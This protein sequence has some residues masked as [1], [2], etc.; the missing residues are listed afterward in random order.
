MSAER[1]N[2]EAANWLALLDRGT[3]AEMRAAFDRWKAADA[4]HVVA[5]ARLAN[6]W[7]RLD[8]LSALHTPDT[9]APAGEALGS[10]PARQRTLRHA[11]GIGIAAGL[12]LLAIGAGAVTWWNTAR[13]HTYATSVG[14]Y[15]RVPLQDGSILELNT[16]TRV[17]LSLSESRRRV[18]LLHGEAGFDVA[19]D[20]RRPFIVTVGQTSI[21]AVGTQFNVRNLRELEIVVTEGRI[22]VETE[23]AK[24]NVE[25]D[26]ADVHMVNAGEAATVDQLG[27]RV[28]SVSPEESAS[29][30]A[31]RNGLIISHDRTLAEIVD[32]FNRYSLRH[33]VI[34]DPEVASLRLGGYF[35][36][37]N[38]GGFIATLEDSF[39]IESIPR[40]EQ[41][42]LRRR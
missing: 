27:I 7:E 8:Q 35:R 33:V 25:T 14:G 11:W 24:G 19:H 10:P 34:P 37:D 26:I 38:L 13:V 16:D 21:R 20:P 30:T 41:I 23:A 31:W 18:Q 29:L 15:T 6:V 9:N 2:R 28:R 5:Y 39:G 36:T 3:S 40:G 22:A 1:I 32:E 12:A 4:R 42:I 17:R